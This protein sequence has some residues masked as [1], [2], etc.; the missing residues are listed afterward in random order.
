MGRRRFAIGGLQVLCVTAIGVIASQQWNH[1]W[2]G[3]PIAF[4]AALMIY[5]YKSY[6]SDRQ[7]RVREQLKLL[8][9]LVSFD[10]AADVRCTYHVPWG[11]RHI[12]QVFDYIPSGGGGGR[13]LLRNKG[14]GG[15]AFS[16]KNWLVANFPGDKEYRMEMVK[17]Y[18]YTS[19]ELQKRRA[20]R[21]SYFCYSLVDEKHDV[22][23]LI[24]FDASIVYTF[25]PDE[26]DTKMKMLV[27][28]CDLIKSGLL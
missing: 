10:A 12:R 4:Y 25:A 22:I 14:I 19:D 23:G 11:R 18:G 21:R 6:V 3:P 27:D 28:G 2:F 7:S 5:E 1:L 13:K 15:K 17:K 26:N 8:M 16:E 9:K 20:D 24:Y